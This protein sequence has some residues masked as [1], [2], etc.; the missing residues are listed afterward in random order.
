MTPFKSPK[1]ADPYPQMGRAAI[2]E[3]LEDAGIAYSDVEQAYA[4]YVYGD[5]CSGHHVVYGAGLTGIPVFNVNSN[6]STGSSALFLA[7]QAVLGGAAECALAVGFE[8]MTPGAL[9]EHWPDRPSPLAPFVEIANRKLGASDA[10]I[11]LKLFGAAGAEYMERYGMPAQSFAQITVKARRHAANNP[12]AVF[13]DPLTVEQVMQSPNLCD[14]LTRFMCCPPTCGAAAA[15]VCSD[16]FARRRG[17]TPGVRIRAQAVVTDTAASFD[18]SAI[19]AVGAE[20]GRIAAHKVYESAGIGPQDVQVVEMHDCFAVNEVI[21]YEALGLCPAGGAERFIADGD[22]TYG[23][24]YVTNPSGGLISKGHP[25]G[26]TGL[27]QTYELV[28]QLRGQAGA[29]QVPDARL[30]LAHNIGLGGTCVVTLYEGTRAGR[31]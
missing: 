17:L 26:A 11:T 20:I 9:S 3:A 31:G 24:R 13:K 7:R 10:P 6:C 4:G 29:R 15:V 21:A 5:S 30:A 16:E 14:P 2:V 23:G 18:G 12:K 22:N 1:Q 27:A 8:Q 28:T 25:L 19:N